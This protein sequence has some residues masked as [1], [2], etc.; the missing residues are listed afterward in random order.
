[1]NL[2]LLRM[3]GDVSYTCTNTTIYLA[4]AKHVWL[5]IE[6]PLSDLPHNSVICA[7]KSTADH[8][9]TGYGARTLIGALWRATIRPVDESTGPTTK[10]KT[11]ASWVHREEQGSFTKLFRLGFYEL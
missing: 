10:K 3:M 2:I 9:E 4:V 1:M 7:H 11:G 5:N 8:W 6:T